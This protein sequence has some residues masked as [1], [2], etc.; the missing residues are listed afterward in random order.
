MKKSV[1]NL[2][3]IENFILHIT[4]IT[5]NDADANDPQTFTANQLYQLAR[6]YIAEDHADGEGNE[7]D[8]IVTYGAESSFVTEDRNKEYPEHIV[9]V[10]DYGE[11]EGTRTVATIMGIENLEAVQDFLEHIEDPYRN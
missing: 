1:K 10:G 3:V 5:E 2:S 4:H 9:I 8:H 6:G 7:E 11:E